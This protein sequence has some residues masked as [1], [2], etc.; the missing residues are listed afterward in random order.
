MTK[1]VL[2]TGAAGVIGRAAVDHLLASGYHV[3]ALDPRFETNQHP[4]VEAFVGSCSDV[5]TVRPAIE[6]VDA[7]I[8]LAAT[9]GP[10][11]TGR[12]AF[13]NNVTATMTVLSCAA[14]AGVSRAAI[15]S[16]ISALGFVYN[17][18]ATP[19]PTRLPIDELEGFN[20]VEDGYA[21]S[22]QTDEAIAEMVHRSSG[23][24]ILSLRLPFTTTHLD[25]AARAEK[26]K[27]QKE[28]EVGVREFWSYLDVRDA[29]R[30]FRL[31][32]ESSIGGARVIN[33]GARETL[34]TLSTSELIRRF[35]PDIPVI[36]QLGESEPLFSVEKAEKLLGFVAEYEWSIEA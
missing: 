8:H 23:M 3:R 15:A 29:A 35:Y 6:G 4:E 32:I 1:N 24:Q 27:N 18:V 16:S 12:E 14:D 13:I 9:P 25:I 19:R 2:I 17:K 34:S 11:P 26:F 33:I 21:L 20:A 22:K 28:L 7:V 10:F 5:S 36:R 31:A 30:A